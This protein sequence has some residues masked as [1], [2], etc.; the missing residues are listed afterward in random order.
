MQ[1]QMIVGGQIERRGFREL[2]RDGGD[3]RGVRCGLLRIARK[4]SVNLIL[5]AYRSWNLQHLLVLSAAGQTAAYN[6]PAPSES[7]SPAQT[8][9]LASRGSI[10]SS[11]GPS[12]HRWFAIVMPA[13]PR[14]G[15]SHT[16]SSAS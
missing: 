11:I 5:I 9:F 7:S 14:F 6:P 4:L 8:P 16:H 2:R 10:P 15:L 3:G 12:N 13:K 1:R